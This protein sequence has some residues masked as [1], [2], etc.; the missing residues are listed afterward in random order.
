MPQCTNLLL[1]ILCQQLRIIGIKLCVQL[2][3]FS[4]VIFVISFDEFEYLTGVWDLPS[5]LIVISN[6]V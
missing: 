2:H 3:Q 6:E 1:V 4:L 5:Q